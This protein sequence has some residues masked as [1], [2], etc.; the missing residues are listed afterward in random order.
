MWG[1]G[2]GGERETLVHSIGQ[3]LILGMRSR[4]VESHVK[5]CVLIWDTRKNTFDAIKMV[6]S[7]LLSSDWKSC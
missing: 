7:L 3:T 1:G 4:T 2:G 5:N 6:Q